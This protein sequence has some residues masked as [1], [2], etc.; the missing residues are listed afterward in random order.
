MH[1]S[2]ALAVAPGVAPGSALGIAPGAPYGRHTCKGCWRCSW[3]RCTG[4]SATT[5][6]D[7]VRS[8]DPA[9]PSPTLSLPDPRAHT[10]HGV[11]KTEPPEQSCRPEVH[12]AQQSCP[13]RIG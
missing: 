5:S 8:I 3:V 6:L 2:M 11:N 9:C 4:P 13:Q 1:P 7:N 10:A 12:T